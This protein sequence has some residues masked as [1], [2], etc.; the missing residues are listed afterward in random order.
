MENQK[1][2]YEKALFMKLIA[3]CKYE[4]RTVCVFENSMKRVDFIV[5]YGIF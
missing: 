5:V 4:M 3:V 1:R 2:E